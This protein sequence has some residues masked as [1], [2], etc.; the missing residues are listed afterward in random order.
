MTTVTDDP[1]TQTHFDA[2]QLARAAA[3]TLK[4]VASSDG[5]LFR[6]ISELEQPRQIG[7]AQAP[8]V[9]TLQT[10]LPEAMVDS[11][12]SA[13]HL[14]VDA[15]LEVVV[16]QLKRVARFA[17]SDSGGLRDNLKAV[18]RLIRSGRLDLFAR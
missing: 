17:R 8:P 3:F 14:P 11:V 7:G 16:D 13:T 2:E 6:C 18:E 10:A 4:T 1:S 5:L 12:A 15:V 9:D